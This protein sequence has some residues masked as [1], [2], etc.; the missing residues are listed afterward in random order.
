MS[1]QMT[2]SSKFNRSFKQKKEV[3]EKKGEKQLHLGRTRIEYAH[4]RSLR[5]WFHW[6]PSPKYEKNIELLKFS[7]KFDLDSRESWLGQDWTIQFSEKCEK[8]RNAARERTG[9][10]W[11]SIIDLKRKKKIWFTT[12]DCRGHLLGQSFVSSGCWRCLL[13][14]EGYSGSRPHLFPGLY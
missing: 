8:V 5:W 7:I 1:Y 12:S 9:G 3:A 13:Q 4:L 14:D 2:R 11:K 6:C 10:L